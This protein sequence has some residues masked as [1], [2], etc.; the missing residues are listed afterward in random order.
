MS[1]LVSHNHQI[2]PCPLPIHPPSNIFHVPFLNVPKC[3]I[4]RIAPHSLPEAILMPNLRKLSED[5]RNQPSFLAE[6]MLGQSLPNASDCSRKRILCPNN[7]RGSNPYAHAMPCQPLEF[8]QLLGVD[9]M[10]QSCLWNRQ[11]KS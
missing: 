9:K 4:S 3:P 10:G 2:S 11:S 5:Q 8:I 7:L 6:K 1:K